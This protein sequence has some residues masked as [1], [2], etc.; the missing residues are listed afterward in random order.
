MK[1]PNEDLEDLI[2]Q[3]LE[4][5]KLRRFVTKRSFWYFF[6]LYFG[7]HAK[8]P[9]ADFQKEIIKE[10]E[11]SATKNLYLT[12]FRG[13]GK[14]TIVSTLYPLWAILGEQKKKYVLIISQTQGQA[15]QILGNIRDEVEENGLLKKDLGP[16]KVEDTYEKG[17][18]TSTTLEFLHHGAKLKVA[19]VKESIRGIR[20]RQHRPDLVICDD[21]E[22]LNSVKTQEGRDTRYKWIKGDVVPIG[23]VYTTRLIV[24]GNKLHEDSVLMRLK[25]EI[26]SGVGLGTYM[27]FPLIKN[28]VCMWPEK[29]PDAESL[30]H[31]RLI[32]GN[33]IEWQREFLLK[34]VPD[35][36]QV[37]FKEYLTH[38]GVLPELD[39]NFV[40]V[41]AGVDPAFSIN[42]SADY[43]AIV[44]AYAYYFEKELY[45]YILSNPINERISSPDLIDR[46]K[47]LNEYYKLQDLNIQFLV[48]QAGQQIGLIDHF[49]RANLDVRGVKTG[50]QDKKFRQHLIAPHIRDRKVIFADKGCEK[51]QYQLTHFGVGHDDLADALATLVLG[52]MEDPPSRRGGAII[53]EDPPPEHWTDKLC[54]PTRFGNLMDQQF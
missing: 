3:M 13:S 5:Q 52:L 49:D 27:E 43:T 42:E 19:S 15:K 1:I 32:V 51:L 30:E 47:E 21:I 23:D 41:F 9:T 7:R 11:S 17:E 53:K 2:R 38:Y 33:D 36:N 4:N 45:L 14:S 6:M 12:A 22:D 46:C 39:R 24:V 16:F 50:R 20:Y 28:G 44:I 31:Q 54:G 26:E 18:W 25:D 29:Y 37:I 48:E 10:L 34:I 35:Y 40:G 8:Y